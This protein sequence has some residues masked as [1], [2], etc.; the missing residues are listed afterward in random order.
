M[1]RSL[2]VIFV[3]V[4]L[5]ISSSSLLGVNAATANSLLLGA[6]VPADKL[7]GCKVNASYPSANAVDGDDTYNN[8][9]ALFALND[10]TG[11]T[12][13]NV[14][15][16]TT[17]G[18]YTAV[19][20]F[21]ASSQITAKSFKFTAPCD[22]ARA[23]ALNSFDIYVSTTGEN[24]SY[25]L[26]YE[27]KDLRTGNKYSEAL[28]SGTKG[29]AAR[30]FIGNLAQAETFK[31]VRFAVVDGRGDKYPHYVNIAELAFYQDAA[32]ATVSYETVKPTLKTNGNNVLVGATVDLTGTFGCDELA[33]YPS[34]NA[35]DGDEK[36]AVTADAIFQL[37]D[38]TLATKYNIDGGTSGDAKYLA[39]ITYEAK[40]LSSVSSFKY[41]VGGDNTKLLPLNSFDVYVSTTGAAGSYVLAYQAKDLRNGK[42]IETLVPGPFNVSVKEFI[43]N[44][45]KPLQAK[46]VRIAITDGR[47]DTY[48]HLINIGELGLYKDAATAVTNTPNTTAP[49]NTTTPPTFDAIMLYIPAAIVLTAITGYTVSK[50]RVVKN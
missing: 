25:K 46:Y 9:D 3:L 33:N 5:L 38:K 47:G 15:G 16:G 30:F 8:V 43:A 11:A 18:K 37:K 1:K 6:N 35:V 50:K 36:Y 32:P 19:I 41:V 12:K 45:E 23:Q 49:G 44:F 39:L 4:T 20:T 29:V 13:Y 24:G 22:A 14:D 26:V 10:T 40:E 34:G 17:N 28:V 2:L 42:L 31:Y 7:I 48:P 21:E 27:A